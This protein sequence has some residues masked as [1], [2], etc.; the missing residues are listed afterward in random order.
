VLNRIIVCFL[1][2]LFLTGSILLP[3]GDFSLMKDLPEMYQRYEKLA[4]PEEVGVIDFIGD[5]LFAGKALFGHNKTDRPESSDMSVQFQHSP[6]TS[7]FLY[8]N[9][10]LPNLFIRDL[11]TSYT[12][13]ITLI[14]TTD[15]HA[16]LL[17]PP[18]V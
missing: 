10:E 8:S 9:L 3:L 13:S 11:I 5:Y 12:Q 2:F 4:A 17:R 6:S 15:F 16:E 18:L 7:S 1:S 14:E